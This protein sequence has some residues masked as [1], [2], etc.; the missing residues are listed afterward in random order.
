MVQHIAQVRKS[1]DD[2]KSLMEL[3]INKLKEAIEMKDF[4]YESLKSQMKSEVEQTRTQ[5]QLLENEME[6]QRKLRDIE[7]NEQTRRGKDD[8]RS[9]L[10]HLELEKNVEI[11]QYENRIIKLKKDLTNKDMEIEQQA[12][13]TTGENE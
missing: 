9:A 3:Q 13:K 8:M 6:H 10:K 4:E 1:Q 11:R 5:H 12:K 7:L 2:G